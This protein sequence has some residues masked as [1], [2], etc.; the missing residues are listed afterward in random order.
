MPPA[1]Q[2]Q[3]QP[4]EEARRCFADLSLTSPHQLANRPSPTHTPAPAHASALAEDEDE[5][6]KAATAMQAA[7]R[8]MFDADENAVVMEAV[9]V[10]QEVESLKAEWREETERVSHPSAS[11]STLQP[12]SSPSTPRARGSGSRSGAAE[13]GGTHL[14][15]VEVVQ[16]FLRGE[17]KRM[18]AEAE[19]EG[20]RGADPLHGPTVD[21][22]PDEHWR[23]SAYQV[24]RSTT[25]CCRVL[26]TK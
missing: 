12:S 3:L 10:E 24:V 22:P 16:K 2:E 11:P 9:V 14:E 19:R 15:I 23:W 1:P 20:G 8:N 17:V 21:D 18:R 13:G 6:E 7:V 26:A 4:I 25:S 5:E